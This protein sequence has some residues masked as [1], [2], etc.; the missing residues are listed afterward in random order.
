MWILTQSSHSIT[1][2]VRTSLLCNRGSSVLSLEK[3]GKSEIGE[4]G[5][6]RGNAID[7][8]MLTAYQY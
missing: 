8:T 1:Q 3:L 5:V 4:R 2:M 6:R 7:L